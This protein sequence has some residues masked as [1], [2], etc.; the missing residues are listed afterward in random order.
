MWRPFVLNLNLILCLDIHQRYQALSMAMSDAQKTPSI[1]ECL[2]ETPS[3]SGCLLETLGVW[4]ILYLQ[5]QANLYLVF[6]G[7]TKLHGYK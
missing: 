2:L 4:M 5:I 6:R 1:S 7:W 3:I